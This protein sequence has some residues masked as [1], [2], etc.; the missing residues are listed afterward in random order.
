MSNPL[1]LHVESGVARVTLNRPDVHNAF[2]DALI[3]AL[4]E[5][6]DGLAARSDVRVVLL[7]GAGKSFC[8]GAD[9][10]WMQ[11]M[12]DYTEAENREDSLA[13]ARMFG[14][15]NALPKPVVARMH[16]AA[17][18]GGAGLVSV[19]DIV[20]A[21]AGAPIGFSEVRLGILP[22]VISPFVIS[23]IGAGAAR[24]LFLT[25]ERIPAE[26][27]LALGLV[28][29]VAPVDRLDEEID[30]VVAMLLAGGPDALARTKRL[31]A[32]VAG[33]TPEAVAELTAEAIA[34][35]RVGHEGQDGLRAFLER[36]KPA[37]RETDA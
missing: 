9:L 6:A 24:E 13:M 31:I 5:T 11:R 3:T 8:A 29:R 7:A 23:R 22:A 4:H 37:W 27:A 30:A 33:R 32:E 15:W 35:A 26:R 14:A 36:R 28:H 34:A 20:V 19:C 18:G 25:G 21:A 10:R 16:G 12:V 2:D 1:E 17:I